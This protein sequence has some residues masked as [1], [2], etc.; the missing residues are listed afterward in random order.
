[1][2]EAETE[3]LAPPKQL[4]GVNVTEAETTS[5]WTIVKGIV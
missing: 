5:G 2:A 3:P 4:T 1:M